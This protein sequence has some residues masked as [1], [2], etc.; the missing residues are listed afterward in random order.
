MSINRFRNLA[1]NPIAQLGFGGL[2]GGLSGQAPAQ[3]ILGTGGQ[4]MQLGRQLEQQQALKL[5]SEMPEL[6]TMQKNLIKIAPGEVVKSLLTPPQTTEVGTRLLTDAE[7]KQEGFDLTDVVQIDAKGNRK[8][9][10]SIPAG[11]KAKAATRKT[12]LSSIDKIVKDVDK[13]GT[14]F[15]EARFKGLS[16]PFSPTQAKFRADTKQLELNVIK[17]LRGAQVS[18]AEEDN[19]R[20]ILPQVTDSETTFKAKAKSLR[21]YLQELDTRIEGG[22]ITKESQVLQKEPREKEDEYTGKIGADGIY[23]VTGG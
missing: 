5:L 14:G 18:A 7:K 8:V 23:D 1:Y 17:A 13:V 4:A 22:V 9:L 19:V 3:A 20:Q 16:T 2:L 11:E 10:K 15:F 21:E 6:T 12:V